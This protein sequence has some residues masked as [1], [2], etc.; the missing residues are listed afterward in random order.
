MASP[1]LLEVADLRV[2]FHTRRG[3]AA[4]LNGVDFHIDAGE[5]LC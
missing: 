3:S 2:E 4:V 5:T 1:A